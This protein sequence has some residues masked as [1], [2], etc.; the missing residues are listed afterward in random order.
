MEQKR[1]SC[2]VVTPI[3]DNQSEIRRHC[4]GII[5]Q[6]I[7]PALESKFDVTVAHRKFEIGSINDRVIKSIYESDLVVA[8]L[9]LVNPNVMFE[10]GIRFSFGKPT[11]VIA[12]QGTK[13]PFDVIDE[14]TIFYI[15]DPTGAAELKEKIVK[16]EENIDY[17]KGNYGPVFKVISK[18]PLYNDIESGKDVSSEQMLQYIINR[19]DTIEKNINNS[20]PK[21]SSTSTASGFG[22]LKISG[23]PG[24]KMCK[25][26]FSTHDQYLVSYDQVHEYMV[27]KDSLIDTIAT[28]NNGKIDLTFFIRS[29]NI[30]PITEM[31]EKYKNTNMIENFTI[32]DNG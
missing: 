11:I 27:S 10:L 21:K 14:N 20:A 28:L 32:Y 25:I 9:S 16:F 15:N 26:I 19:L 24:D 4:D 17:Q 31:L 3:G 23:R 12:E 5:D 13:L 18:V 30:S 29:Y 1:K 8:N 22:A 2:F 7:I 6:A